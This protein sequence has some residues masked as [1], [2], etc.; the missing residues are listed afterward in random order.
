MSTFG[1]APAIGEVCAL[2]PDA[3]EFPHPAVASFVPETIHHRP[4]EPSRS[5]VS[6]QRSA[7]PARRAE[8]PAD[9]FDA[10]LADDRPP[11]PPTYPEHLL[12]LA[13]APD[14]RNDSPPVEERAPRSRRGLL[15][16]GIGIGAA[17]LVIGGTLVAVPLLSQG[18]AGD[19]APAADP[20]LTAAAVSWIASSSTPRRCC[21]CRTT[22]STRST[23]GI[24][25]RHHRLRVHSRR[26]SPRLGVAGG[27]LRPGH[28]RAD[29]D[30]DRRGLDRPR[31]LW[32]PWPGSAAAT[33]ASRCGACSI[34]GPT[35][36]RP[37]RSS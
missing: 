25:G 30:G 29:L 14:N 37:R 19:A 12:N 8:A 10:L 7:A 21:S 28:A 5:F 1:V 33:P 36:R 31:E 17:V 32:S 35:P 11:A 24:P 26:R 2:D 16:V 27:R 18:D 20:G 22:W 15:L 3:I 13:D 4:S 34:R 6:R 23:R 9:P